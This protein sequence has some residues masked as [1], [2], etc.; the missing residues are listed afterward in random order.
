VTGTAHGRPAREVLPDRA[1]HES[2]P[3]QPSRHGRGVQAEGRRDRAPALAGGLGDER[4]AD[5]L[6]AVSPAS[7]GV[8]GEQDVR[9]RAGPADGAARA[10]ALDHRTRPAHVPL[11]RMPPRPQLRLTVGAAEPP[12]SELDLDGGG[13]GPY[14]EHSGAPASSGRTLSRSGQ[15]NFSEGVLARSGDDH[16]VASEPSSA[17]QAPGAEMLTGRVVA[18]ACIGPSSRKVA[19]A[20]PSVLKQR[21]AQQ[22]ISPQLNW[23]TKQPVVALVDNRHDRADNLGWDRRDIAS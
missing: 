19:P 4:G 2:E 15:I 14:D 1:R 11:D 12:G 5:H 9:G 7:Q 16:R 17:T 3:A 23:L 21:G 8:L 20:V 18:N 22:R 10:A 13:V 6:G